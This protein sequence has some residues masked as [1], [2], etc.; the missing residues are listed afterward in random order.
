MIV[1]YRQFIGELLKMEVRIKNTA[2][3]NK[4]QRVFFIDIF[5][6]TINYI[7][8]FFNFMF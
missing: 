2:N 8:F 4:F 3:K 7:L 5:L 1:K 6:G